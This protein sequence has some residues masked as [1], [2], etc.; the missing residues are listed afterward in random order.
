MC[1]S[2]AVDGCNSFFFLLMYLQKANNENISVPTL[3]KNSEC[4]NHRILCCLR[5]VSSEVNN[6]TEFTA[7]LMWLQN[8]KWL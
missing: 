5:P 7:L 6:Y 1:V 2:S 4:V 3:C 8:D